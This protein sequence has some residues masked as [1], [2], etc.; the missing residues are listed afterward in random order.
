ML[1]IVY[2]PWLEDVTT[3]FQSLVQQHGYH[4]DRV[5]REST[6]SYRVEGEVIFFV[7]GLRFDVAQRLIKRLNK[8]GDVNLHNDWAALPSVTATAKAAV[9]PVFDRLTGRPSDKTLNR[10]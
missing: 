4:G 6:A 8:L 9:T 2:T 10:S 3:N 5:A 1:H 7:D